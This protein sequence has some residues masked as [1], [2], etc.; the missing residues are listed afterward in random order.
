MLRD[1]MIK[2]QSKFAD[3]D[4]VSAYM[5]KIPNTAHIKYKKENDTYIAYVDSVDNEKI[6]G[7]LITES[8]SVEELVD[9]LNG[10]IYMNAEIPEKL[11]PYYGNR[12]SFPIEGK[13]R[14]S[15]ELNLV[16]A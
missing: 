10:L 9:N 6:K 13:L 14:K 5:S 4:E 3:P 11:R 7:L 15:G 12:F 16:K 2:I 8:T 1:Y